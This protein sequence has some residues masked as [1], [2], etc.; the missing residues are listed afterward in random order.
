MSQ[1]R[2]LRVFTEALRV[3]IIRKSVAVINIMY[4]TA[5]FQKAG[6]GVFPMSAGTHVGKGD[7]VAQ[8]LIHNGMGVS[9][10]IDGTDYERLEHG[11]FFVHPG[12]VICHWPLTWHEVTEY[13]GKPLQTIWCEL[14]GPAVPEIASL[15]G[16]TRQAPVVRP[17]R[18]EEVYS[19]FKEIVAG[20]HSRALFHPGHFL[21]RL[22]RVA[23]LC[24]EG[25]GKTGVARRTPETL[26]Q[27]AIRICETGMLSFPTV[28]E[29]TKQLGV[30]QSTL[31]NACRRELRISAVELIVRIKLQKAKELLRTTDHKLSHIAE[32]CGFH[33]LSHFIHSFREAEC[34]TPGAWRQSTRSA[35]GKKSRGVRD[36]SKLPRLVN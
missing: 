31:L 21:Q 32:A 13:Q 18:P 16:V 28:A 9:Y 26:V 25:A 14:G 11:E 7:W 33:S 29:L 4:C 1:T 24:S 27:R 30:S 22:C 36:G 5:E 10:D 20:F 6:I 15:F 23:E 19:L 34:Q 35:R 2:Q 12:E 17:A 8:R 3:A